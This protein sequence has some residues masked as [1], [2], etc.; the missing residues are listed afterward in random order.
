MH[1]I[2][3]GSLSVALHVTVFLLVVF[4]PRILPASTRFPRIYTV[5][6]VSL[7]AGAPGPRGPGV[8]AAA[9]ASKPE[10]PPAAAP[11][12]NAE[13]KPA[14]KIPA[15]PAAPKPAVKKPEAK[16]PEPK[17]P[18]PKTAEPAATGA[19]DPAAAA[20]GAGA[21]GGIAGAGVGV[22][23]GGGGAGG[24]GYLDDATFEYGWYLSRM[25]S[26]LRTN[27]SPPVIPDLRQ[28][29]RAVVHFTIRRDGTLADIVLEQ[30]S[31]DSVVDRN[32][33]RAVQASNPLPPLPYQ[34]GKDSLGVH[35][36]FEIKP[37]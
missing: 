18:E 33:L 2:S 5:D 35:F 4:L 21:P 7:P 19:Q 22:P 26:I 13:P 24:T 14:V 25:V 27:W 30:S 15:K 23:G 34:Y 6:L 32:A 37:E 3:M 9:P 8:P 29:L 28:T 36:Y 11:K 20:E 17:P 1:W 12:P 31:G 16:K 10:P